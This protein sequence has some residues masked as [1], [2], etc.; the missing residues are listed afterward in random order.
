[1]VFVTGGSFSAATTD[2]L[3][4]VPNPRLEKPFDPEKLVYLVASRVK[5]AP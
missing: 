4:E 1:M 3:A 5:R 2:F